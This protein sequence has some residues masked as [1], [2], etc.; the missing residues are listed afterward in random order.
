MTY[1]EA[2]LWLRKAGGRVEREDWDSGAFQCAVYL[3]DLE[4]CLL[5]LEDAPDEE[6]K[7]RTVLKAIEDVK[8]RSR[9]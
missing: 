8:R 1:E 3:G 7:N 9:T 2:L 5:F 6:T 4:P